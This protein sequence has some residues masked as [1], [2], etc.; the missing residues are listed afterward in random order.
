MELKTY[1]QDVIDDL[2]Q[3]ISVLNETGS[4]A[5]AFSCYWRRKG[6]AAQD[7]VPY[8]DNVEG[9]A[10][11]TIKVPTAGGKTFIACNALR[12]IFDSMPAQPL[13]QVVVWFVPS[14]TILSQTYLNLSNPAHPYRQRLNLLFGNR[15]CV[16]DKA[17]ALTGNGI[18]PADLGSQLTIFVLSVQSF[19]ERVQAN[20]G[21]DKAYLNSPLAYRENGNIDGYIRQVERCFDEEVAI[22]RADESSL[23]RYIAMLRPVTIIDESHN[24]TSALRVE[25]LCN[26]RPSFIF[27]LTATPREDSNI[28]SYVDA[29]RL[30]GEGMVKLPVIVYNNHSKQD[31]ISAAILLRRQLEQKAR[32][33]Q[34]H[35]GRYVRPI[36]LFQAET[37][38]AADRETYGKIKEVLVEAGIPAE[39]IKIKTGDVNELKGT[40]LMSDQCPVRYII[41]V[42]ALKEGWDC[43][44]AYIL[45]TIANRSSR[46]DVEQIIGRILRQPYTARFDDDMLNMSYVLTCSDNFN[47]TIIDV[48]NGLNRSGYSRRDYRTVEPGDMMQQTADQTAVQQL[49]IFAGQEAEEP[50][51][52]ADG[53]D[54]GLIKDAVTAPL[55]SHAVVAEISQMAVRQGEDYE[56][57]NKDLTENSYYGLMGMDKV[58]VYQIRDEY[59]DVAES[60]VLPNFSVRVSQ[61][62][63]FLAAANEVEEPLSRRYLL[64]DFKLSKQNSEINFDLTMDARQIDLE[65]RGRGETVAIAR[66]LDL[67]QQRAMLSVMQNGSRAVRLETV[68]REVS[69]PLEKDDETGVRECRDYVRNVLNDKSDEELILMS[70]MLPAVVG[71]LRLKIARLKNAAAAERFHEMCDDGTLI[72]RPDYHFPKTAVQSVHAV[73]PNGLYQEE[74]GNMDR[75]EKTV[76]EKIANLGNVLFWHRNPASANGFKIRGYVRNHYPDFIVVTK[77]GAV[78]LVETKGGHLDGSDSAYKI[79]IGR[80]WASM[81]GTAYHYFMV[82]PDD[83]KEPLAGAMT[84]SGLMRRLA[85]M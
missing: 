34:Q 49:G 53:I 65:S 41:T 15:V 24:F 16:V 13:G 9:V 61:S 6:L 52:L 48:V 69:R 19:I 31:V 80:Q 81:A 68:V 83:D 12:T 84:V 1:Q 14:D 30:K 72:M 62:S 58:R 32:L 47:D 35:G 55:E 26:I 4:P 39:E 85:N 60:I 3:Y 70:N 18:S 33:V 73:Y 20:H 37:K 79:E 2:K 74:D 78:V 40:D 36:V 29:G 10:N 23:I 64:K 59:K 50:A 21:H 7:I 56:K 82:F 46:V 76:I 67:S 63:L 75:F 77:R 17:T 38:T 22:E 43:P 42:N 8:H 71:Q 44:F 57:Q 27:D 11:V 5:S 45:A 51:G 66:Q 25:T 28:I 54:G